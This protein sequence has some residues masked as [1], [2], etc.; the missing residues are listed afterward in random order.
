MAAHQFVRIGAYA[1]LGGKAGVDR[2]VPPFVM[3]A[4][5]RAKLYGI[6][7]RGLQRL[8]FT[9]EVLDG[10]K[11]AYRIIWREN[12]R[13]SEGIAQVKREIEPFPE[14]QLLLDFIE[15]SERGVLR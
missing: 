11:R 3:V 4:G 6:N 10:L 15:E 14:L 7:T 2:D 13:F 1:F 9:Q 12:K 5:T 8:G